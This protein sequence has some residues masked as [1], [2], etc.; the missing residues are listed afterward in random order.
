L[1]N[2]NDVAEAIMQQHAIITLNDTEESYWFNRKKKLY[3]SCEVQ[4][5]ALVQKMVGSET[6]S[7]FVNEVIKSIQRRTLKDRES[8][9]PPTELIPLNNCIYDIVGGGI[10][11][12]SEE[13]VFFKKHPVNYNPFAECP[14]IE[15]FLKEI[16]SEKDLPMLYEIAGYCFYRKYCI[17]K[18]FMLVGEGSNGKSVYLKLLIALLG[19]ENVSGV[20]LQLLAKNR[21]ASGNLYL[22]NANIYPDLDADALKSTGEIKALVGEDMIYAERKFKDSFP[23][24]N[25]AKLCFSCNRLPKT[26]D[27][28]DA[29]YR[30]WIIIN[31]PNKFEKEERD[32]GLL[33][34]LTTAE[35][36]SGFFNKIV[37]SLS[38]LLER[39]VFSNEE[40]V[41]AVR[42]Y[43]LRL[44]D[45]TIA[46]LT[47]SCEFTNDDDWVFK[48]ELY[49]HYLSYCKDN[50]LPK[51]SETAFFKSLNL[52]YEGKVYERRV[53]SWR[54]D[55]KE[56]KRAITGIKWKEEEDE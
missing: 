31:F 35:E 13:T 1:A 43:Y 21:F 14:K 44:S 12:Y 34:K 3:E 30:R 11:D 56:M 47:D 9:E 33:D 50:K 28:S 38:G 19:K 10:S 27:D 18:C 23:F 40:S 4:L 24:L 49:S 5:K 51:D 2:A 8:I 36:L 46:F 48:T 6:T 7:H 16:V 41:D 45:S 39:T 53:E 37:E 55:K 42:D 26:S 15:K 54:D 32:I 22:K 20:S 52:H 17:Q 25:Y 29:F